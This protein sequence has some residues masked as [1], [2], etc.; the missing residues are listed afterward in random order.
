MSKTESTL[1]RKVRILT[2][3][4]GDVDAI[5]GRLTKQMADF[6]YYLLGESIPQQ[7]MEDTPTPEGMLDYWTGML[8]DVWIRLKFLEEHLDN[9][10]NVTKA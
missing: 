9:L 4:L 1:F 2:A 5:S 3:A 8:Q 10:R 6:H 7:D